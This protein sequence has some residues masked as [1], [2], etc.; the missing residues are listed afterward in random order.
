MQRFAAFVSGLFLLFFLFFGAASVTA[1]SPPASLVI[2]GASYAADW[3]KPNLPGYSVVNRGVGGEETSQVR[4][5]TGS[6]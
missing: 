1:A 4:A 6:R 3:Q 5:R 2:I